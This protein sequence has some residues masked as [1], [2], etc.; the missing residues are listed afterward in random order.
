MNL[1]FLIGRGIQMANF[2]I[3]NFSTKQPRNPWT[4]CIYLHPTGIHLLTRG[5]SIFGQLCVD[6]IELIPSTIYSVYLIRRPYSNLKC[7][8]HILSSKTG[9][10]YPWNSKNP[11]GSCLAHSLSQTFQLAGTGSRVEV[12]STPIIIIGQ[13]WVSWC[14]D[15]LESNFCSKSFG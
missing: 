7:N 1:W 5:T 13:F 2:S 4:S 12:R 8:V 3:A 14:S 9:I 15:Y 11:W 6:I 10:Y